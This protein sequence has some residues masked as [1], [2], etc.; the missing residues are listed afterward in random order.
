[1]ST[2]LLT[3]SVHTAVIDVP[4]RRVDI[5]EWLYSLSDAEYRRC[6]PPD[7]LTTGVGASEDGR[8]IWIGVETIDDALLIH[9]F[10]GA[11]TDPHHC[12]M[13]STSEVVSAAG[14]TTVDV[15]WELRAE[16]DGDGRCT[17]TDRIL[18]S[19]TGDY[20]AHL[21]ERGIVFEDAAAACAAA[22]GD[23]V[24]RETPLLA[25]SIGRR[26]ANSN[27]RHAAVSPTAVPLATTSTGETDGAAAKAVIRRNAEEVHGSGDF[28]VFDELFADDYVDHTPHPGLAP[29]K[30][31]TKLLYQSMRGAFPDLRAE[32]HWQSVD[33]DLVTTYLTYHGSHR[34]AFLGIPPSG[35]PAAFDAVD[36]M[37]VRDGRIVEHWGSAHLPALP[38]RIDAAGATP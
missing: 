13:V 31:G 28:A 36:V 18:V 7:H 6:C 15:T 30:S 20:F 4:A 5:A 33:G 8:P 32:I 21:D 35:R 12:R 19:P 26:A 11:V 3:D 27:G 2:R 16:P 29:D 37:R 38:S 23:H 14:R 34:G 25:D 24:R 10:V 22:Y 9:H 1:M 17:V